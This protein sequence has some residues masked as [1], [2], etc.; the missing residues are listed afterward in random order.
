MSKFKEYIKQRWFSEEQKQVNKGDTLR[1]NR[2]RL[3]PIWDINEFNPRSK[4]GLENIYNNLGSIKSIIDIKSQAH[5]TVKF[6]VRD[7]ATND[8]LTPET[9][10]SG[11]KEAY[12]KL[13][14]LLDNPNPH[15]STFEWLRQNNTYLSVFGDSFMYASL[16]VGFK[17]DLMNVK[18]LNNVPSQYMTP[19]LTGMYFD[20]DEMSKIIS[21]YKF[22][23]GQ[24]KRIFETESILQ[25]NDVNI[26]FK[27]DSRVSGRSR[28]LAL[29]KEIQN[30]AMSLESRN[31]IGKRRGPIGVFTGGL[32][33]GGDVYPLLK[34]DYEEAQEDFKQFGT[35]DEQN[36]FVLT[37]QPFEFQKVGYNA[38]E[39]GLFE[40]IQTDVM[41]SAHMYGVPELLV[42]LYRQGA[43]FE[44]QKQAFR[45]MFENTIIPESDD[46]LIGFNNWLNLKEY[47]MKL[48]GSF[49]HIK[50]LQENI[51][52]ESER[53]KTDS[54]RMK[55]MFLTDGCTYNEWRAAVEMQP[56]KV[57]GEKRFSELSTEQQ[58][59]IL[60][61]TPE[62]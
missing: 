42:K 33:S 43:T 56:D 55:E 30:I 53:K 44:N 36:S 21:K 34:E 5:A 51:K 4:T 58:I 25:R 50:A 47:G 1:D 48:E 20:A 29:R 13:I 39:L 19:V 24:N 38:N 14:S 26:T 32:K 2:F 62:K 10:P 28:L 61:D 22:E 45:A 54:T 57:D 52:E 15:Q 11:Q 27:N 46:F 8:L 35:L 31:K 60:G 7:L 16:P 40:E 49:D 37:R 12:F 17:M 9:V 18:V 23:M 6:K 59:L 3:S 41:Q